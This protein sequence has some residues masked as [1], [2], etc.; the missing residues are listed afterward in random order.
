MTIAAGLIVSRFIHYLALSI[1]FGAAL[2]PFYGFADPQDTQRVS[3]WLRALLLGSA[4]LALLSGI[5]WFVFTTHPI[6]QVGDDA[7][8]TS[9]KLSKNREG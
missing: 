5:S 8:V 4:L 3:A 1:L 9:E 2:F 6:I 7:I